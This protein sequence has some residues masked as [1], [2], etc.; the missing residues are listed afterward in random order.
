M[1]LRERL[2]NACRGVDWLRQAVAKAGPDAHGVVCE[3]LGLQGMPIEEIPD[4][5]M[6]R[7]LVERFEA[8][9]KSDPH[10]GVH[11]EG[12]ICERVGRAEDSK[13]SRSGSHAGLVSVQA[14]LVTLARQRSAATGRSMSEIIAFASNRSVK[15]SDI[16]RM[17]RKGSSKVWSAG[18]R[19][20][21]A[22][23]QR[24]F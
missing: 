7:E 17:K 23:T 18:R 20:K 16:R 8:R 2:A 5:Q 21:G 10:A 1:A 19:P 13:E 4:I 14:S 24:E 9:V 6:L 12:E 15:H 11:A 3:E 22:A